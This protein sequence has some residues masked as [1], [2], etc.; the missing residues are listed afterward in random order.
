MHSMH[1]N[2]SHTLPMYA[3]SEVSSEAVCMSGRILACSPSSRY[4]LRKSGEKVANSGRGAV[5]VAEDH[6]LQAAGH[7]ASLQRSTTAAHALHKSPGSLK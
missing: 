3:R 4:V 7:V 5:Q 2:V 6:A 1:T